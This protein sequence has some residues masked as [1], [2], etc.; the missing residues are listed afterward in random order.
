LEEA[1]MSRSAL[2]IRE[3]CPEDAEGLVALWTVAGRSDGTPES[4]DEATRAIAQLAADP[5]ER[6]LVGLVGDQLVAA[7][8]LRRAPL[9]PLHTETAVHTSYL[10]VQ[11]AHRRRGYARA[12][13]DAALMWA[14]EKDVAHVT[15]L[16]T[17]TSRDAHRF[18][19][20]LGLGTAATLRIASTATVRRKL[21]PEVVRSPEARRQ[22]GRMVAHRRSMQRR[23]AQAPETP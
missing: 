12:L 8:H 7:V 14:E 9:S 18:L 15:A 16:A 11:P 20:R 1:S 17:N 13:L 6:M 5:D 4:V 21:A 2:E 23:L 3:A 19:A 10:L 22:I